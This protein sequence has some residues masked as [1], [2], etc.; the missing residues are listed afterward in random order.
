M[1]LIGG[2]NATHDAH[3]HVDKPFFNL[4]RFHVLEGCVC[5]IDATFV[6]G[7]D[8]NCEVTDLAGR[9]DDGTDTITD[10]RG[11]GVVGVGFIAFWGDWSG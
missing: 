3:T 7:F 10:G 5:G 6:N 8:V 4:I 1:L 11:D 9:A 2:F